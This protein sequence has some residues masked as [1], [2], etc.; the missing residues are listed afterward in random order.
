MSI[1]NTFDLESEEILKPENLAQ[2][3]ENFPEIAVATF[4]DKIINLVADWPD[5]RIISEVNHR[6]VY[7]IEHKGKKIAVYRTDIGGAA[8][9]GMLELMIV[10]GVKKFVFFGAC[11]TLDKDISAG[12]F[13]VP[14]AAYRDEGTSYHYLK[15][16]DYVEIKT[17]EKLSQIMRELKLPYIKAKTWTTD[18][19]F[20]ETRNNML[21]RKSEGCVAVEMEC[22]SVMAAGQFRGVEVY[23][24]IYGEDNLDSS[25]W[26]RRTMG[27]VTLET[28]ERYL[29]IALDIAS[30]I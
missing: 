4:N 19:I 8:S 26:E 15:A 10:K 28:R 27:N 6:N 29:Y 23:Q 21:K 22:A 14:T 30:M 12:N 24:F 18:A 25:E 3:I 9:A 13:I 2:R 16:G 7:E 5:A 1:E 20:R 17:A 11:G